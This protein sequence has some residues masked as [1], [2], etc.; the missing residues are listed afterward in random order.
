[1]DRYLDCGCFLP[2]DGPRVLCPTCAGE[3]PLPEDGTLPPLPAGTSPTSSVPR[4]QL[5]GRL[6]A[7]LEDELKR[8]LARRQDERRAGHNFDSSYYDGRR[9][10]IL[11]TARWV[12]D[13]GRQDAA[14]AEI[15]E[16]W[17]RLAVKADK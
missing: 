3:V 17:D 15:V 9:A 12:A 6:H 10:Q 4:R 7:F 5:S 8:A 13:L 14:P 11:A 1:M 2:E 16:L